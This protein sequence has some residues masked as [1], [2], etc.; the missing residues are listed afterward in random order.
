MRSAAAPRSFAGWTPIHIFRSTPQPEILWSRLGTS[1]FDDPFFTQTVGT[2]LNRPLPKLL[3]RTTSLDELVAASEREPAVDPLGF[4]FHVSRCGSTLISQ[5]FARLPLIITISEAYPLM[6]ATDDPR[7][8]VGDRRRAFRALVRLY[9]RNVNGTETGSVFKLGLREIFAWRMIAEIFPHV[10]RLVLHRD[11]VEVLVSNLTTPC[12]AAFP[13]VI[14]AELLGPSP[15]PIVSHEDYTMF[16]FSRIYAAALDAARAPGSLVLDYT[17]L[18]DAVEN[19]IAPHFGIPLTDADRTAMRSASRINAKDAS[20]TEFSPDSAD[21]QSRASA[22]LR[23]YCA[24]FIEP[25][26]TQFH[27]L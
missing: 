3:Q 5:M 17:A 7:L 12:E 13:G 22:A 15:Q 25:I 4:I 6:D 21:K 19:R 16:V 11:P 14:A 18:P 9:G 27:A 24:A 23:E 1:R 20:N 26:R 2:A 10:P 8:S